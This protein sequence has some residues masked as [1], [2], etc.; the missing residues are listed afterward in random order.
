[1]KYFLT[2]ILSVIACAIAY[3]VGQANGRRTKQ[4]EAGIAGLVCIEAIQD[5]VKEACDNPKK[6]CNSK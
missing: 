4:Y 5:S 2:L 1:M 3:N 6:V